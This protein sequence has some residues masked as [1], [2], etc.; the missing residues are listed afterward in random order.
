[1]SKEEERKESAR[2]WFEELRDRICTELEAVEDEL[3]GQLADEQPGR[4]ER[5]P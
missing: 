4:F 2:S 5:T 3:T 1:M